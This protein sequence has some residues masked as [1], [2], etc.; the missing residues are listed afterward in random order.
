[1]S[2]SSLWRYLDPFKYGR[3]L[4]TLYLKRPITTLKPQLFIFG[5]PRSG[6]TLVYQYI[7]HRL[8]VAYFTNGVGQYPHAPICI[9]YWQNHRYG[10]YQSDFQSNYGKVTG[11]LSPR[12]AGGFWGRYFDMEAYSHFEDVTPAQKN[13]LQR[14]IAAIQKLY[15][16]VA[17]VNKNVKHMLRLDALQKIFPN[18]L[19]LIVE[20]D[21]CDVGLSVL[22]GRYQNLTDPTEWWSVRPPNYQQLRNLPIPE[23]IAQQLFTLQQQIEADLVHI[24]ASRIFRIHYQT[25]CQNPEHLITQL[26]S[27]L[28]YPH[29]RN[30]PATHFPLSHHQPQTDEEL[31]LVELL[32][33]REQP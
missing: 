8:K 17:F 12:E 16:D 13:S 29:H 18:S 15:G 31:H 28:A 10:E 30:P 14:T 32:T 4:E 7:V 23:Q 6:T 19:F 20:R 33:E 24:H 9:T 22:H 25:F 26:Y 3:F 21:L 11:P 27:A 2:K 5:L 1:M